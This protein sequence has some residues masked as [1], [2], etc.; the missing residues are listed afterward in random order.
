MKRKYLITILSCAMMA[1][2]A[3]P[4]FA[5]EKVSDVRINIVP[6]SDDNMSPGETYS[7]MEPDVSDSAAYYVDEY[8]VSKTNPDPKSSYTYTIDILPESGYAFDSSTDVSVY[9]ATSVT[10]KSRSSSK[11][12]IKAKTYPF[13]VLNE[14]SNIKID[15]TKKEATW[16]KV[17]HAKDY[18]V[19]VY[20]KNKNGDERDTKKKVSKTSIDLSGY[21]G[22]YEDV[23]ISVRAMKGS[24]E[25]DKFVSNS[26]YVKT[27]GSIDDEN[28]PD[29]YEFSIPTAKSDGTTSSSTSNKPSNSTPPTN[30]SGPSSVNSKNDG[31]HGSGNNWYYVNAGKKVTGWLGINGED[32]YY[33]NSN[34]DMLSGW[35]K[36]DGKWYL[37]NT[38]HDGTYG[39]MLTGWQQVNGKWYYLNKKHDGTFGAMLANTTTPDGYRV[40][41]D[42]VWVQ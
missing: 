29:E 11:I 12:T 34:G 25:G 39:K 15:E 24:T 16:N 32:W 26:D 2:T 31:W 28:S 19:I 40:N 1:L 17:D 7:G 22:K 35:Q 33:F 27:D 13:H 42:G 9:G 10:V 3:V 23:D 41:A 5:A 4:T 6:D 14:V 21:I 18:S 38:N 36:V 30:S 8:E 37:M 20:Y